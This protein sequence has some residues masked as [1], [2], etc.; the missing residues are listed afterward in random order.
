MRCARN[1]WVD[2]KLRLNLSSNGRNHASCRETVRFPV[3][4]RCRLAVS[5]WRNQERMHILRVGGVIRETPIYFSDELL[6]R[7]NWL[8]HVRLHCDCQGILA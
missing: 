7:E 8:G 4:A 3:I 1:L 2:I 5:T 6:R